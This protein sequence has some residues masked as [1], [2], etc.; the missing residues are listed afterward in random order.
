MTFTL[1]VKFFSRRHPSA[2]W[3][4]FKDHSIGC[5]LP[6]RGK[7]NNLAGPIC[8]DSA[9]YAINTRAPRLVLAPQVRTALGMNRLRMNA[10]SSF[11]SP[12]EHG[13][14]EEVTGLTARQ[15]P[16]PFKAA[17]EQTELP[18]DGDIPRYA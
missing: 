16:S 6:D 9:G 18:A 5:G 3:R 15:K 4:G 1:W 13:Y 7:W 14:G 10:D 11:S 12:C 17:S 2:A 8:V